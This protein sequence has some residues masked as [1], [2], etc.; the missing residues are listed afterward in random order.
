MNRYSR[1]MLFNKIGEAGQKKIEE[2]TVLIIGAGALGSSSSEM[3]ARAGV[4]KLILVDRDYVEPSNLQRQMLY[5]EMHSEQKIPKVVGA[6]ERLREVRSNLEIETHIAHCDAGLLESLVPE[7][8]L[9]L[10]GT[11]NFDTRL[12]INDAAYKWN[13]PWVYAACV[14]A[15]YS[16]CGFIPGETPCYRC[17][18]PVLPAT[19]LTCDTAGIISPAVQIAVSEQVTSALKIMTDQFE[20]PFYLRFG[21]VWDMDHMK[22]KVDD[23][24]DKACPTCSEGAVYP[25]LDA[26]SQ[27]STLKLCGRDTVQYLD[28]RLTREKVSA[29]LIERQIK[30]RETPYFIEF[31]YD[32]YRLIS[33]HDGRF[34][35]HG[36]NEMNKGRT[37]INQI[38][39]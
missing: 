20:P 6:K 15:S 5:S 37:V 2:K 22:F 29:R 31:H 21:N 16:S 23:M 17:M 3:L 14:E 30:F 13:K 8:D 26:D 1:Q 35:I 7:A 32:R 19:T 4:K 10:D 24:L 39:G 9:I 11:D 25:A 33:F 36:V 34:L 27:N 28:E 18:V 38:F 12:L